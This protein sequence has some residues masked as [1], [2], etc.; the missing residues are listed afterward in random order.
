MAADPFGEITPERLKEAAIAIFQF[1]EKKIDEFVS[2][3]SQLGHKITIEQK[4]EFE[5]LQYGVA[6]LTA[7]VG[8]FEKRCSIVLLA[9]EKRHEALS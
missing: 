9:S 6:L 7:A 5:R 1:R 2:F 8:E 4:R 3:R